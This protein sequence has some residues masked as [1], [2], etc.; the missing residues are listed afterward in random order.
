MIIFAFD[1]HGQTKGLIEACDIFKPSALILLGDNELK[2]RIPVIFENVIRN[3]TKVF[4][5]RGN[6]DTGPIFKEDLPYMLDGKVVEIDGLRIGGYDMQLYEVMCSQQLDIVI[7]HYPP[8]GFK[9]RPNYC[10]HYDSILTA[11]L[12]LKSNAVVVF[13]GH[14]HGGR[15]FDPVGIYDISTALAV[16]TCEHLFDEK[17]NILGVSDHNGFS[18]PKDNFQYCIAEMMSRQYRYKTHSSSTN[19]NVE[20]SCIE[21]ANYRDGCGQCVPCN[22]NHHCHRETRLDHNFNIDISNGKMNGSAA[23]H[24]EASKQRAYKYMLSDLLNIRKKVASTSKLKGLGGLLKYRG[25]NEWLV[26][27]ETYQI[28]K[29]RIKVRGLGTKTAEKYF[30]YVKLNGINDNNVLLFHKGKQGH[31]NPSA[32]KKLSF[33]SFLKKQGIKIETIDY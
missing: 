26:L 16:S 4:A 11:E 15:L 8:T 22:E 7:S 23:F 20:E 24:F 28:S 17:G 3:G 25:E 21:S 2:Q 9:D 27:D 18:L 31:I 1:P 13:H 19:R 10:W 5:I 33:V 12:T 14:L 30:E 6:H 29:Q 32:D